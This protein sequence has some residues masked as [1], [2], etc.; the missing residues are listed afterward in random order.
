VNDFQ[1]SPPGGTERADLSC[2]V[3]KL[4][5]RLAVDLERIARLFMSLIHPGELSM[6]AAMTLAELERNGPTRL[7]RPS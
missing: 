4:A 2:A 7:T 1:S 3:E 6:T 5:A